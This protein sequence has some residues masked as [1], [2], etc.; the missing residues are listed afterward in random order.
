MIRFKCRSKFFA[1]FRS[2]ELWL[3]PGVPLLVCLL[4]ISVSGCSRLTPVR[5]SYYE[6]ASPIS[7]P[8]RCTSS[9]DLPNVSL[10]SDS[11]VDLFED[12]SAVLVI[13]ARQ[14][15][16]ES[17][18]AI[19]VPVSCTPSSDL[20]IL[21]SFGKSTSYSFQG[22]ST[23]S[24]TRQGGFLPLVP[25]RIVVPPESNG[26]IPSTSPMLTPARGSMAMPGGG[27]YPMR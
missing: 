10:L 13:P 15:Y 16:Q 27:F 25:G 18:S 17:V 19:S 24:S 8:A 14:N 20:P 3:L 23:V 4:I 26:P 7:V 21:S 12:S 1:S 6:P 5:E 22:S 9:S 11:P 2:I